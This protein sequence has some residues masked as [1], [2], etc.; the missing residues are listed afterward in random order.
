MENAM[1]GSSRPGSNAPAQEEGEAERGL[2]DELQYFMQV[3]DTL[4]AVREITEKKDLPIQHLLVMNEI[5]VSALAGGARAQGVDIDSP[6]I[7][8]RTATGLAA[9]A[10]LKPD[11]ISKVL[12]ALEKDYGYVRSIQDRNDRRNRLFYP[13]TRGRDFAIRWFRQVI[14]RD[15]SDSPMEV[16]PDREEP[17]PSVAM[18]QRRRQRR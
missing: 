13:T 3:S 9:A 17:M 10:G 1:T 14:G 7:P 11:T 15:I 5:I 2:T 16:L 12:R 8:D 4:I 18:G 6:R